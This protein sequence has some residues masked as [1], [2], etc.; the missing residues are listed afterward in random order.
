MPYSETVFKPTPIM[1]SAFWPFS[2]L[3]F[4]NSAFLAQDGD[5]QVFPDETFTTVLFKTIIFNDGNDYDGATGTYIAPASGVYHFSTNIIFRPFT[6]EKEP[7]IF[8]MVNG[9]QKAGNVTAP[10][11]NP[12]ITTVFKSATSNSLSITIKLTKNDRVQVAFVI[13]SNN[14][15]APTDDNFIASGATDVI[16]N[17][18][19]HRI[20]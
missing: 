6:I 19:G 13:N 15:G 5:V 2:F 4:R 9:I 17:F 7:V 1:N 8:L 20:Y 18:S 11:V 10:V 3:F 16:T 12:D 14:G